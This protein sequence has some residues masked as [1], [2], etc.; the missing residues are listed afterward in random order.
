M[1][2]S[3]NPPSADSRD[4]QSTPTFDTRPDQ[5][6]I[7]PSGNRDGADGNLTEIPSK[8][9]GLHADTED[10]AAYI[11]AWKSEHSE[12]VEINQLDGD[13]RVLHV[14]ADGQWIQNK[15]RGRAFALQPSSNIEIK[16]GQNVMVA[17][18]GS[19]KLISG[20]EVGG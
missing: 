11:M 17:K 5:A 16:I 8:R 2:R 7:R 20:Q 18:D 6:I 4:R 12:M 15:N 13:G 14:F 19:V 1:R 3:W 9:G 10:V